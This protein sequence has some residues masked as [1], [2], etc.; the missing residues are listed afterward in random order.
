MFFYSL[1]HRR[2]LHVVI[3]EMA[4]ILVVFLRQENRGVLKRKFLAL[5]KPCLWENLLVMI[6]ARIYLH[7]L[8]LVEIIEMTHLIHLLDQAMAYLLTEKEAQRLDGKT[9]QGLLVEEQGE[10]IPKGIVGRYGIETIDGLGILAIKRLCLF[11]IVIGGI[12]RE[13]IYIES[14]DARTLLLLDEGGLTVHQLGEIQGIRLIVVWR[15]HL[16]L[17]KVLDRKSVV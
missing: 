12:K 2:E 9:P 1:L 14:D 11:H 13:D 4:E 3:E 7:V 15:N 6:R 5:T 8:R 17:A 16:I 10:I